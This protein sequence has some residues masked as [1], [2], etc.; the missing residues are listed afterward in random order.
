MFLSTQKTLIFAVMS[1]LIENWKCPRCHSTDFYKAK[2][3]AGS[4]GVASSPSDSNFFMARQF[5]VEKVVSLCRSC[6]ENMDLVS[7]YLEYE[8][9]EKSQNKRIWIRI[10]GVCLLALS[11]TF[12]Q[13]T[14][15]QIFGLIPF[16]LAVIA[17]AG[18]Y[19]IK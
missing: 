1:T 17:F 4:M 10:L 13:M 9:G 18:S 15:H 16:A 8:P 2:R 7:S 3:S 12:T 19:K 11:A 14:S 6:G 5:Q